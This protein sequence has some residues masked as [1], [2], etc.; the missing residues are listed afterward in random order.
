MGFVFVTLGLLLF[1]YSVRKAGFSE[2]A[3]NIKRL[4][5]G[6][7]IVVLLGALRH[8]VHALVWTRCV[9]PPHKLR[10]IDAFNARLM[11]DAL[12]NLVPLGGVVVSE[13]SKAMFVRHKVPLMVG[14]SALAI[15]NIFYALSV[16]LFVSTGALCLL[17]SFPLPNAL[18]F[19]S[20]GA[21]ACVGIIVPI[22]YFV[23]RQQ[24]RFMSRAL[25][26]IG[27]R[28]IARSKITGAV[29]KAQ[30]IEDRIYGFYEK[31]HARFIALLCTEMCFHVAGVAEAY[32]TLSF[33]SIG[34][35]PTLLTAFILESVNR[36]I[37]VVFKF[38]P[39]RA[40]V[41]E[42]GTGML[43]KVL[44]F[45]GATGVTLAIVRKARDVVLTLVGL[46]LMVHR[47]IS[48]R[49]AADESEEMVEEDAASAETAKDSFAMSAGTP[50]RLI[51]RNSP[52]AD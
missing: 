44:G 21:L 18:R 11:G 22:G 26:F 31:N 19:V 41:D 33:V 13:P 12:G 2:I 38:M 23:I 16:A 28:G 3:A 49:A 27:N 34:Q 46:G 25:A 47:G 50:E 4:G 9:E 29:P 52:Q 1:T 24:W 17:L 10:F 37:T 14:A 43:S 40:G 36:V 45:T 8:G 32:L 30:S 5:F 42:A 35:K 39:L 20:I 48:V 51:H 6:F 7:A 15:E